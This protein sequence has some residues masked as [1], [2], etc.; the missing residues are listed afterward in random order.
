MLESIK[1]YPILDIILGAILIILGILFVFILPDIGE[2]IKNVAIGLMILL[3]V[4]LLV[5]PGLKKR[6]SQLI[7][8][9]LVLEL[10]IG[11]LVSAMF[12]FNDGGNPSLWIGLVIYVHGVVGLIGGYF[13]SKKQKMWVFFLSLLFV[14]VGVY[15]FASEMITNDMLLTILLILFLAPGLF[16]LV[17]GLFNIKKAKTKTSKEEQ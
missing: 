5:Y 8:G 6:K 12:I 16:F 3:T 15:I 2:S 11:I 7:T 4:I 13:S 17:M 9:L 1:K 14:T 10:I